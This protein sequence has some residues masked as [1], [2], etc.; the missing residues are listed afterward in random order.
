M[1]TGWICCAALGYGNND[2]VTLMTSLDQTSS[3]EPIV[4]FDGYCNLCNRGV[5]FILKKERNSNLHFASLQSEVGKRILFEFN[6][7]NNYQDSVLFLESG[8]LYSESNAALRIAKN[9]KSPWSW[10]QVLWVI[11]AFLRNGLY[12]FIAK[13]RFHWFGRSQSCWVMTPEWKARFKQ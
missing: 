8:I 13:R 9:L 5:R 6:Y 2:C 10:L 3:I 4:L 12:R 7:P 1:R 11:P